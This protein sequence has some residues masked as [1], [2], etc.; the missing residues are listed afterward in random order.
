MKTIT[1][2]DSLVIQLQAYEARLKKTETLAAVC[3]A[4]AGILASLLLLFIFDRVG[5]TPR[6]GRM[7]LTFSGGALAAW[8]AHRWAR[9]WLWN[10]R[11]PAQL[12]KLLQR[13]FKSLGDRLQGIIELTEA[14]DLPKDVSPGLMRAAI[15]QVAEDSN[16]FDFTQAVP[17]RPMRRWAAGAAVLAAFMLAPFLFAPRAAVNAIARWV[18][19]WAQIERYTF[20]GLESLPKELVVPHGEAFEIACGLKADSAWKPDSATA[21]L[22]RSEPMQAKLEKGRALF[23]LAGQTHDGTLSVRLGDATRDVAIR[24]MHRPEIKELSAQV[25]LPAYLGYPASTTPIQGSSAE[26]LEGSNVR[27]SAKT[28]RPLKEASMKAGAAEPAAA[29]A[30]DGFIT[31]STPVDQLGAETTF[32]WADIFGLTPTQPY[33]VR[34]SSTKDAEPRIE[35]QGIEQETAILP[36]EVL[37][38]S[39]AAN[40]DYG[41]KESWLGWTVRA[42]GDKK[43]PGQ[44]G[45]AA[46]TPGTQTT[47]EMANTAQFSPIWQKIPEDSI[48][49]LA[50][51]ALDYQP[52]RKPVESWKH[53]VYVLSLTKHAERVRE[54]MDA[55]LRQLNERIRDEERQLDETA[56]IAQNKA[57]LAG[58]KAGEQMKQAESAERANENQLQKLTDE[59][60]DVMKD[61]LRNKEVPEGT[62]ADWQHLT[63]ALEKQATPPMQAASEALAQGSQQPQSREQQLAEAQAQQQKALDAMR[64]AAE[65]MNTTN[66][67]L[68]ARNFY[69]RMR[70]A[71]ATEHGIHDTLKNLAKETVGLTPEQIAPEHKAGFE[72]NATSQEIQTKTVETLANDMAAFI[73]RVPNEKY[74]AVD[75]E[76]REKK[77]VSELGELAGFVRANLRLK[78]V[79]RTKQWSDQLDEWATMLQSE[80]KCQG[81]DGE[82]DP[83]LMEL[84]V[85]LVRAA[86]AQDNIREQTEL[87][88]AKKDGNPQYAQGALALATQQDDLKKSLD[89]LREKTKF[90]EFKPTMEAAGGFMGE[91]AGSFRQPKTDAEVVSTEAAIIELLVPPD[92]KG[93]K[94][95]SKAQQMAQKMMA[96]ATK[97]GSGG[98][99]RGR[100]AS[101]LEGENA[102]GAALKARAGARPVEKAGAASNAGDWPEEFRDQLQAYF[103]QMEAGK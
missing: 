21:R 13:H 70:A 26:F 62:L 93:G 55:T 39:F 42:I 59:M 84:V 2:P 51:Y 45:E 35:L 86:Q 91:V 92:K 83:D 44:T 38:L 57:D 29:I 50:A 99:N 47:R 100:F 69:N 20:A 1:L 36:T 58:E 33:T 8:F 40:D 61:A 48:V 74:E 32:R 90:D 102:E 15:R 95:G 10:R 34:V 52:Q 11:G 87:L 53:T 85:A 46:R 6:W 88:E 77:V 89:D 60:R 14:T 18:M 37:R 17:V 30:Q 82:M 67:Q 76:M 5:D 24:P 22:N 79:G 94:P 98:G 81:G 28:S 25:E 16:R 101:A 41:I 54:R 97:A 64:N 49:E 65:K 12:A 78:A 71:A 23:H 43:G 31:P 66:E 56:T 68:Y 73:K 63:E 103:Q 9:Q 80:C 19:P 72:K 4:I 7:I 75:R 27:F 3:G 96:Q